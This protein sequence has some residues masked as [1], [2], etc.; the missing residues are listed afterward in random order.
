MNA[1]QSA[2]THPVAFTVPHYPQVITNE[3][4]SSPRGRPKL[5]CGG[6][7]SLLCSTPLPNA[8]SS[9]PIQSRAAQITFLAPLTDEGPSSCREP[10]TAH[11]HSPVLLRG[12]EVTGGSRMR[13]SGARPCATLHDLWWWGGA[14]SWAE[15][16][17]LCHD[18]VFLSWNSN[19]TLHRR[20]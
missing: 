7:Q 18:A 8:M 4:S 11:Q 2:E 13:Q 15:A 10:R 19:M 5:P 20:N 12:R 17:L 16:G 9:Q 3:Y 6:T 14:Y 1:A